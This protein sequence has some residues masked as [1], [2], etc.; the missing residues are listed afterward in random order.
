MRNRQYIELLSPAKNVGCAISAIKAGADAV[1]MGASSF[2]ARSLAGNS[3]DDIKKSADFAHKFGARIYI[4]LNTILFDN[5]V[6]LA[7]EVAFKAYEAGADALIIQDMGLFNGQLPPIELHASTQCNI[8]T[9]QK[10]KLLEDA[11][12]DTLVL[13]R[14]L[15]L[16]EIENIA[17][18]TSARIECFVHGALCVSYSGQC[19]LSYAIGGRSGN[20]GE[21][22]Q[23][24]RMPYSLTDANGKI[25]SKDAHLLS[26]KDMNRSKSIGNMLASGV[27][28]FKIE[29]R[30]KDAD[31]VK[32]ITSYYRNILD[33]EIEKASLK[34]ASFGKSYSPFKPNPSKTF[35]RDF[36][37]YFL[38][39]DAEKCA[40]FDTP[41][42]KGEFIG[43][44][45]KLI[46]GGF[47][48]SANSLQN[49]D[50]ILI[51][52][53]DGQ[54]FGTLVNSS[55][56]GE[57]KCGFN[58]PS[59]NKDAEIWRNKSVAFNA[60][61]S[62]DCLRKIGITA[63]F[64]ESQTE[65]KIRFSHAQTNSFAEVKIEKSQVELAQ[66]FDVAKEKISENLQKTGSTNFEVT[67]F[68]FSAKTAPFLKASAI[69]EIRRNLT[70]SL[71][72]KIINLHEQKRKTPRI[73][74]KFSSIKKEFFDADFRANVL[75]EKAKTFYKT[76][77]I[78]IEE[79]ALESTLTPISG[80]ELMRTKH[81]IL[82][83]LN[84]CKRKGLFPKNIV[85]PLILKSAEAELKIRFNCENCG[86]SIFKNSL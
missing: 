77:N 26:L 54:I 29:G 34:R 37:E 72:E 15:T 8:R 48:T 49:G 36:C 7:R 9:P 38:K 44:V 25:I 27:S 23:P 53:P 12:F 60:Q 28:S 61:I 84:M 45:L 75:N 35:N 86:M 56:D 33:V 18:N 17:K 62:Q 82:R 43:K 10:A 2:G 55:K 66:N 63:E 64:V 78:D 32:N 30:L 57:I 65:Y 16:S 52:N 47:I 59:I 79:L 22:A 40:S 5:E 20:R 51:K 50:G 24:C 83:E 21:C 1:Y 14:E 70:N 68:N 73:P 31:Y 74:Q 6:E 39:D 76:R 69:N 19:Y 67:S 46:K 85:E 11:G 4:T 80:K 13:A 71:E 42:S 58:C 3:F 81:C 41:K